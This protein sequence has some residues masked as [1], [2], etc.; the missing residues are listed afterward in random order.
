MERE[1]PLCLS[2]IHSHGNAFRFTGC[3]RRTARN[4][5]QRGLT[6]CSIL[7]ARPRGPPEVLPGSD[8]AVAIEM[9]P[10]FVV[11][12]PETL[13]KLRAIAGPAVGGVNKGGGS[14]GSS[15]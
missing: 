1:L 7:E 14:T 8:P 3:E 5:A 4:Y 9:H 13:L 6:P 12:S 2:L 10:G 11:Y 15:R